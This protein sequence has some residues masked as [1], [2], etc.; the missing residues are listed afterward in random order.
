MQ[1]QCGRAFMLNTT[2]RESRFYNIEVEYDDCHQTSNRVRMGREWFTSPVAPSLTWLE[3]VTA[4]TTTI[5][6]RDNTL[7]ILRPTT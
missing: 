4:R 2:C 1:I 7:Q 5:I 6:H 3:D